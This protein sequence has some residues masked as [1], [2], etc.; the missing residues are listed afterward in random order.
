MSECAR[1]KIDT[2][3]TACTLYEN[4]CIAMWE[5]KCIHDPAVN[6]PS[7]VDCVCTML[8]RLPSECELVPLKL[9]RKLSYKGHYLYDYVSPEKLTK[10][11]KWLKA[12]N[13]LFADIVIADD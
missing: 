9:K 13:P 8:P 4:G 12:N 11:L 5:Q 7:K 10:A 6:V 2:C 1:T 3:I